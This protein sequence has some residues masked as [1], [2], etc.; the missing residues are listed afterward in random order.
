MPRNGTANVL[1]I[2]GKSEK[3]EM[4]SRR[5]NVA[6]NVQNPQ[7]CCLTAVVTVRRCLGKLYHR[8]GGFFGAPLLQ[9]ELGQQPLCDAA[10]IGLIGLRG[11]LQ[12]RKCLFFLTR[13]GQ[14]RS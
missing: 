13:I 5:K 10:N 6:S 1:R 14:N 9:A 4:E 2:P 11:L 8:F 7:T 12:M 3:A